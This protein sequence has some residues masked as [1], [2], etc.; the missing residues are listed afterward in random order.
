MLFFFFFASIILINRLRGHISNINS[1]CPS[2]LHQD[3]FSKEDNGNG[4][5]V[6]F[7]SLSQSANVIWHF[8]VSSL[9]YMWSY[10]YVIHQHYL[11]DTTITEA[12]NIYN[13]CRS[14]FRTTVKSELWSQAPKK[15]SITADR[16]P[17]IRKPTPI[18]RQ[19]PISITRQYRP[20]SPILT[21]LNQTPQLAG[22]RGGLTWSGYPLP[23]FT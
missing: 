4:L 6:I 1:L 7:C 14:A 11:N 21:L 9:L 19:S 8:S 20:Q 15:Y 16:E 5:P 3:M 17:H 2:F 12:S 18:T 13:Q 23:S 10:A 22:G